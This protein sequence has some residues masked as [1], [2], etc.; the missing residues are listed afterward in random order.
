MSPEESVL[1]LKETRNMKAIYRLTLER[2]FVEEILLL[3]KRTDY[4]FPEYSSWFMAHLAKDHPKRVVKFSEL[5]I[6]IW[7]SSTNPGLHRNM[8]KAL[9]LLPFTE[10]R[11]GE[12]LDKLLF[13]LKDL[14]TKVAVKVYALTYLENFL[15]EYPEIFNEI[16]GI[17]IA[18]LEDSTPAFKSRTRHFFKKHLHL[19][20]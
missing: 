7:L 9:T 5:M 10:Y 14:D 1:Y 15:S 13:Y 4:P 16:E 18:Q 11:D 20:K 17:L 3:S 19:T 6:D 12:M 8:L 2:K